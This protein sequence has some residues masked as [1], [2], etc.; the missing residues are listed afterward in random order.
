MIVGNW[1]DGERQRRTLTAHCM[2]FHRFFGC[3]QGACR[4]TR[5][6]V[7]PPGNRVLKAPPPCEPGCEALSSAARQALPRRGA[8]SAASFFT[9]RQTWSTERRRSSAFSAVVGHGCNRAGLLLFAPAHE[10]MHQRAGQQEQVGPVGCCP[11]EMPAGIHDDGE[12]AD[13]AESQPER[14]PV[15]RCAGGTGAG[16]RRSDGCSHGGLRC[17]LRSG[18][19]RNDST[20]PLVAMRS[21]TAQ[22]R[23]SVVAPC[24]TSATGVLTTR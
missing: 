19:R 3:R 15:P 5:D 7:A 10:Q 11:S 4:L 24:G 13:N 22:L 23:A 18:R 1:S 8:G 9:I 2:A 17:W 6:M 14:I 21:D 16:L 12:H 20:R